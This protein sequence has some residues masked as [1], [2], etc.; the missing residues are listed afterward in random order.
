M[1]ALKIIIEPSL[2]GF[3]EY[4]WNEMLAGELRL[5]Y[6]ELWL[7]LGDLWPMQSSTL[8]LALTNLLTCYRVCLWSPYCQ[9]AAVYLGI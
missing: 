8:P 3:M 5:M 1:F 6:V 2:E 4:D 9:F 7:M